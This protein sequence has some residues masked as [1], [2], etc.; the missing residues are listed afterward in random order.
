MEHGPV[1]TI[2]TVEPD[3]VQT[4]GVV[5]V[6][7]TGNPEDAVA[8][9]VNGAVPTV[10]SLSGPNAIVVTPETAQLEPTQLTETAVPAAIT[11]PASV[12]PF[13]FTV[14]TACPLPAEFNP[15]VG[16][17]QLTVLSAVQPACELEA[18]IPRVRLAPVATCAGTL[19]KVKVLA[20]MQAPPGSAGRLS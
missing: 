7:L 9:I 13:G 19:L 8:L 12:E 3:T 1:P 2:V 14:N 6:K 20:G 17:I 16:V 5:E 15:A 18:P 4:A 10:T 11:V